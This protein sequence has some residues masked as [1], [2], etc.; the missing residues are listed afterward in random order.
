MSLYFNVYKDNWLNECILIK[1]TFITSL[2]FALDRIFNFDSLVTIIL[3]VIIIF[4]V[5]FQIYGFGVQLKL[6]NFYD[7]ARKMFMNFLFL[8][9]LGVCLST[10]LR[11]IVNQP[12]H[13]LIWDGRNVHP[14]ENGGNS[15]DEAIISVTIFCL[16]TISL[17][18]G[19]R[20]AFIIASVI[21]IIF[22]CLG[23]IF[24]GHSSI[25]SA[26]LSFFIGVWIV[27]LFR[28]MPVGITPLFGIC[29]F[30]INFVLFIVKYTEFTWGNE[31]MRDSL[32]L[33]FR[34]SFTL[35]IDCILLII[36]G[37]TRPDYDWSQSNHDANRFSDD[38]DDIVTIPSMVSEETGDNFGTILKKDLFYSF[39]AFLAF[40]IV[41]VI[42]SY[43]DYHFQFMLE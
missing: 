37:Y 17:S 39:I 10:L 20:W 12:I 11:L 34:S 22:E 15:P 29:I 3:L 1:N 19:Y 38:N 5:L 2:N 27:C 13:C 24:T 9:S 23:S 8:I 28:Y 16:S 33:C 21:L 36:F 26:F 41:N 25:S 35:L 32:H 30:I 18:I 42:L 40:L 43:L 31:I 4:P 7:N 6:R 14:T